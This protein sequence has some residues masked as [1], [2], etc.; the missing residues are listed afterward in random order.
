[1]SF[2]TKLN[3]HKGNGGV[4]STCSSRL[5]NY[6]HSTSA[7]GDFY[8]ETAR[9]SSSHNVN[10]TP[11]TT[12]TTRRTRHTGEAADKAFLNGTS[13]LIQRSCS[14]QPRYASAVYRSEQTLI[15]FDAWCCHAQLSHNKK[16][17]DWS[18]LN[19][20]DRRFRVKLNEI[21]EEAKLKRGNRRKL[22]MLV[23]L[24]SHDFYPFAVFFLFSG[25]VTAMLMTQGVRGERVEVD[26]DEPRPV[27]AITSPSPPVQSREELCVA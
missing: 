23:V 8:I 1:M 9:K 14:H 17:A 7:V 4:R 6:H 22:E 10:L 26:S 2:S 12:A 5:I 27:T 19:V 13:A 20:T 11:T 15:M 21:S 3:N 16:K 25:W 24:P 18:T